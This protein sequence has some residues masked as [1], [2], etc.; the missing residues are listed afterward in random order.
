MRAAPSWFPRERITKQLW[1]AVASSLRTSATELVIPA[2]L[3]FL[4]AEEDP[5]MTASPDNVVL[6]QLRIILVTVEDTQADVL[7][8][9]RRMS[10]LERHA[11]ETLVQIGDRFSKGQEMTISAVAGKRAASEN[12]FLTAEEQERFEERLRQ[13]ID[14]T[15]VKARAVERATILRVFESEHAR[16]PEGG[17]YYAGYRE[18]LRNLE[19]AIK[20]RDSGL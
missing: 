8:L 10:S 14:E 20:A 16:V 4:V 19:T 5:P 12:R 13:R 17:E 1:R 15:I 6:E 11:G 18:V 3:K 9:K 7:D 2:H